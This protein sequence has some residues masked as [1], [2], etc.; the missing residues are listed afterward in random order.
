MVGSDLTYK[1][2][3]SNSQVVPRS[4][5]RHL[6]HDDLTNPDHIAMT[7]ACND[8]IIEKIGVPATENDFDKDYLKLKFEYYNDDHQDT[9]PDAPPEHLTPTPEIGDNYLNMELMLPRGGTLTRGRVTE[10]KRDHEGNVIGRS[11]TN[12][13]LDTENTK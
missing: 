12:P 8:N 3:K 2:L 1:I 5:I 6:T 9:A 10:R 4:T 11:N 13:I 7:K